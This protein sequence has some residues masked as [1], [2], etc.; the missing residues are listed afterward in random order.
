MQFDFKLHLTVVRDKVNHWFSMGRGRYWLR[1]NWDPRKGGYWIMQYAEKLG[2]QDFMKDLTE[3]LHEMEKD[4]QAPF[5]LYVYPKSWA[6]SDTHSP[7]NQPSL[8]ETKTNS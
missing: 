2:K 1:L 4:G 5:T 6:K 8:N 7:L 3:I